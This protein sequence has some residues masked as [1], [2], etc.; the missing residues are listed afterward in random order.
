MNAP[1]S[2]SVTF[3]RPSPEIEFTM[4]AASSVTVLVF[5]LM[6]MSMVSE[7]EARRSHKLLG[8]IG[9]LGGVAGAGAIGGLLL[10]KHHHHQPVKHVK[11]VHLHP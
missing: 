10:A 6:A 2:A 4:R 1:S 5:V 9:L 7:L 11:H 8:A 3:V